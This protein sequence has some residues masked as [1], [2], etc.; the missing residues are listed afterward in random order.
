MSDVSKLPFR[1]APLVAALALLGCG[2]PSAPSPKVDRAA[3]VDAASD[4]ADEHGHADD[5]ELGTAIV[6]DMD[7]ACRQGHG[8]LAAGKEMLL[9]VKLPAGDAAA[10][11]VRAWIGTEDRLAS[12]VAKGEYAASHG[13]FDV[14]VEAPDPLPSDPMWWIE[15]EKPD[16]S[17][18]VG[19]IRPH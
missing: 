14:H 15:I 7:V 11:V 16:G 4:D 19:S 6:G 5:V 8:A 1:L 9:V 10:H 13:D 3:E 17:K 12:M 2:E 18:A